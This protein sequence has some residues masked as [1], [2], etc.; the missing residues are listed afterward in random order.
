MITSN[1]FEE[2]TGHIVSFVSVLLGL[3]LQLSSLPEMRRLMT[4]RRM[5]HTSF[6]INYVFALQQLLAI[7]TLHFKKTDFHFNQ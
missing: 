5:K 1:V 7:I 4:Q 3:I 2:K 6:K